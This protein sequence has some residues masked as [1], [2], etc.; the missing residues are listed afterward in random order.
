MIKNPE[1]RTPEEQAA[2]N[3]IY[4]EQLASDR[5]ALTERK[6]QEHDQE[7]ELE[8]RLLNDEAN[9]GFNGKFGQAGAGAP[10]R[11][12]DGTVNSKRQV[13]VANNCVDADLLDPTVVAQQQ[14]FG[15]QRPPRQH[16]RRR[17]SEEE[18]GR[19]GGRGGGGGGRRPVTTESNRERNW[20]AGEMPHLRLPDIVGMI[21]QKIYARAKNDTDVKR[22]VLSAFR[23]F[24]SNKDGSGSSMTQEQL[25]KTV[26][27]FF[28]LSLTGSQMDGLFRFVDTNGDGLI[29]YQDFI[30][31][32]TKTAKGAGGAG[33]ATIANEGAAV[34]ASALQGGGGDHIA[35]AGVRGTR[36]L[37]SRGEREGGRG[38]RHQDDI[39]TSRGRGGGYRKGSRGRNADRGRG[40][41]VLPPELRANITS[42]ELQQL[43]AEMQDMHNQ[44]EA[45]A[46][47][48]GPLPHR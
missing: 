32:F 38:G 3:A 18:G 34:Y 20:N 23:Q 46:E 29:D 11:K 28:D 1:D 36:G 37:R 15:Q 40:R 30:V 7:R 47:R 14:A 42:E 25:H 43:H 48:H 35:G 8:Q 45:Y 19:G 12:N 17:A 21:T 9:G 27:A 16:Q 24:D 22:T 31:A 5:A 26:R 2:V 10:L 33:L 39:E 6:Q 4:A 44:L 13:F 41:D